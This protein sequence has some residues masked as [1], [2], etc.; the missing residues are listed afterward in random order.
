MAVPI[1]IG[2]NILGAVCI[3]DLDPQRFEQIDLFTLWPLA[4][5]V[6]IAMENARLQTELRE[7]A[8]VEERNRIAREIHD[9]LA[10]GFAGV[11]MQVESAKMALRDGDAG[12]TEEILDRIR[13][14]A[15]D[16]LSEARHSVQSLRPN[17]TLQEDLET[18]LR[19][20]LEAI[21]QSMGV[22]TTFDVTGDPRLLSPEIKM[23]L[24]RICQEAINNIKKHAHASQV[25]VALTYNRNAM[26]LY[27][28][29]DGVGFDPQTPS[30]NSFGLT[31][32]NERARLVGGTLIVN[33]QVG[34]GTRIYVNIP[35]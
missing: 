2:K 35:Q 32:M 22:E 5:Q 34:K 29:D 1:K 21:Q 25:T 14:L 20:E 13:S 17:F 33:S 23:T 15:R 10:Q 24:L 30:S 7:M 6:A 12:H 4:D 31:C 28:Q 8:V 18:L 27:V 11:S 9:T 16:K 26:A 3:T 19:G